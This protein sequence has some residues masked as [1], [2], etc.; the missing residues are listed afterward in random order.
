L[1]AIS[2]GRFE[3]LPRDPRADHSRYEIGTR[4]DNAIW[5]Y[6][7]VDATVQGLRETCGDVARQRAAPKGEDGKEKPFPIALWPAT[8][9]MQM[10]AAVARKRKITEYHATTK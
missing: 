4:E 3:D 1:A 10:Y 9:D 6:D 8:T 2:S 5:F 7:R